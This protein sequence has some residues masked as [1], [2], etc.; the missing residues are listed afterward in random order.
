VC[1]SFV[2]R[3]VV[4]RFIPPKSIQVIKAQITEIPFTVNSRGIIFRNEKSYNSSLEGII[5]QVIPE[6]GKVKKGE[7]VA[8]VYNYELE[9][10]L[11]KRRLEIKQESLKSHLFL[12]RHGSRIKLRDKILIAELDNNISLFREKLLSFKLDDAKGIQKKLDELVLKR[13]E[14][15]EEKRTYQSEIANKIKIL[16]K[17]NINIYRSLEKDVSYVFM[18]DCDGVVSYYFDGYE[19]KLSS[20]TILKTPLWE[21]PKIEIN[22]QKIRNGQR[23]QA[24]T[25]VLK[26][27]EEP[28]YILTKVSSDNRDYFESKEARVIL[29]PEYHTQISAS[30]EKIYDKGYHS[31]ELLVVLA[32]QAIPSLLTKREISMEILLSKVS[33][34]ALPKSSKVEKN[35]EVGV[36][37][38]DKY[39][40][41][42]FFPVSVKIEDA[43]QFIVEGLE[44]G[45]IVIKDTANIKEGM[46][47]KVEEQEDRKY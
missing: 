21:T 33:G 22:P 7:V 35:G 5:H 1:L 20:D 13:Q 24:R 44:D 38:V 43:S 12:L 37:I 36:Y 15:N 30:V 18:A 3:L 34:V 47:V 9:T 6:G 25:P 29:F 8:K 31:P 4:I 39:G 42:K 17:E 14:L 11:K 2:I 41:A 10:E 28:C 27:I 45:A 40:K 26:I 23:V 46:E 16:E 19:G 32:G